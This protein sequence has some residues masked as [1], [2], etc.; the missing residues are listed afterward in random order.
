MVRWRRSKG[1]LPGGSGAPFEPWRVTL[2]AEGAMSPIGHMGPLCGDRPGRGVTRHGLDGVS[3]PAE[4][5]E[6]R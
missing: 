5:A 2:P 3:Y 1:I 6:H 4:P